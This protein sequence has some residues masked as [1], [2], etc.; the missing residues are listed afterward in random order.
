MFLIWLRELSFIQYAF[1]ALCVN[2][3]AGAEFTC[4]P[5]TTATC[6]DGDEHLER[7]K[8][9]DVKIWENCLILFGMIVGSTRWRSP[10]STTGSP[11][12]WLWVRGIQHR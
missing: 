4:D 6:I 5:N 7:L 8:F 9:D 10:S 11:S 2:E 12:T 3:F 1:Q